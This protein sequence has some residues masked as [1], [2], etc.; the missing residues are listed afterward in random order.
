MD[1]KNHF[2]F[3][4]EVAIDLNCVKST[5]Y[6]ILNSKDLT[7]TQYSLY[8]IHDS[9]RKLDLFPMKE[10]S[11][12]EQILFEAKEQLVSGRRY[13]LFV[14]FKGVITKTKS[15][16]QDLGIMRDFYKTHHGKKR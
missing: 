1:L 9:F 10:N 5:R 3:C 16:V 2:G 7:I 13:R 15:G 8:D 11:I 6:A 4:G 12:Y 14:T